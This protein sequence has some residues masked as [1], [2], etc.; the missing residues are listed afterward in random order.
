MEE[1]AFNHQEGPDQVQPADNYTTIHP[2]GLVKLRIPETGTAIEHHPVISVPTLLKRSAETYPDNTALAYKVDKT[3]HKITYSKYLENVR[4]TA[5]AFIKLG[6]ERHHSVSILGFNSPEWFMSDLGAIFAGGIA[7]GIYTTNS[8]DA[9]LH[10]LQVSRA[11]ICVVEDDIQLQKIL[12]I[13]DQLPKLKAIVQY[14]GEPKDSSVYSWKKLM[15]LGAQESDDAL[16]SVIKNLAPNECCTLVFTSGTVGNPK[17]VMLNHDN[18]IWDALSIHERA[19]LDLGTERIVSF[20]PLSHVAAQVVDIY[21]VIS[22]GAS[23]YFAD[24]N[25]LKGTLVETLREAEPTRFLGVPRVWEKIREKML[26]VGKQNGPL[27]TAL[28]TWAKGHALQYH[29]NR[30]KG[31]DS[32]SW[33]YNIASA[34]IFKKVKAALGFSRCKG[35]FTAAAPLSA[36]VKQY[37]MSLDIP[38]L[39]VFGMSEAAGAHTVSVPHACGFKTIGCSIPGAKT[40]ILDRD[41]QGNG[42][43]CM[44]GRHIFMGYLG[45]QAK[46]DE[47][48]DAEGWLHSGDLGTV[49]NKGFVYITGRLKEL[50]ITAGG[51]NVAPVPIEDILK[52]QLQQLSNVMLVGDQMKFISVLITL[53]TEIDAEGAPISTLTKECQEWLHELGC[54]A[55]TT[56]EVLAAGP[57]PNLVKEIQRGIDATNKMAVSNA[58]RIQKFK[59][60]ESD[61]SIATGELG[62]TLKLKRG[63]VAKK[64]AKE[65]ET[66]YV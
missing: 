48:I 2:D 58:Q 32:A 10:C 43:I 36:E 27:K 11:N 59:I 46:T 5:K 17:A 50:I 31:I 20:L 61:F 1:I 64:F 12:S 65:I 16:E 52:N 8:P 3:W 26:A 51:E 45:E 47:A 24:K 18:L 40:K 49:D 55:S 63:V 53:K 22:I 9:C 62:P 57:H 38:V 44:Y 66:L 25:A 13:R 54:P 21:L 56:H 19:Q 33:S 23:V 30:M 15:E 14:T 6:L 34:L 7:A 60:L 41:D 37:F 35:Y 42:E 29:T 28:A 39:D 4:T